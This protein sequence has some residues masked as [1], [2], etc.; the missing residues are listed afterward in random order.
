MSYCQESKGNNGSRLLLVLSGRRV[1]YHRAAQSGWRK[2]VFLTKEYEQFNLT[3]MAVSGNQRFTA[4]NE[5]EG[6]GKDH[7][8]VRRP[9]DE[10]SKEVCDEQRRL[11]TSGPTAKSRHL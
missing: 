6:L 5:T 3:G 4:P 7:Q 10:R 2:V 9:E 8:W 1:F 11:A